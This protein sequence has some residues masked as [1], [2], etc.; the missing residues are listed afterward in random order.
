MLSNR[1]IPQ[2]FQ[3]FQKKLSKYFQSNIISLG[4]WNTVY[5]TKSINRKVDWANEDHCGPCGSAPLQYEKNNSVS[6]IK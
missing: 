2:Y 5:C 6:K 4:R 3:N 1:F